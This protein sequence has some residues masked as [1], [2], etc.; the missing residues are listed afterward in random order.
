MRKQLNKK[1][2]RRL[3]QVSLWN[4]LLQTQVYARQVAFPAKTVV[5]VSQIKFQIGFIL[6]VALGD[7]Q[8]FQSYNL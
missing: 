8:S 2:T 1:I 5:F 3:N 6:L 7:A 4:Y